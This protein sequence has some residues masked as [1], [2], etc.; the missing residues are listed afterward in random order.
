MESNTI[1]RDGLLDG[2]E[3][4]DESEAEMEPC[5]C[6]LLKK[7]MEPTMEFWSEHGSEAAHG[8]TLMRI[9]SF[10]TGYVFFGGHVEHTLKIWL[11]TDLTK[12]KIAG[13]KCCCFCNFCYDTIFGKSLSMQSLDRT[14][15]T[16]AERSGRTFAAEK[17]KERKR[18]LEE[19]GA[20]LSRLEALYPFFDEHTLYYVETKSIL[21][22]DIPRWRR[23]VQILSGHDLL[24]ADSRAGEKVVEDIKHQFKITPSTHVSNIDLDEGSECFSC[25]VVDGKKKMELRFKTKREFLKLFRAVNSCIKDLG[26]EGLTTSGLGLGSGDT[27][28]VIEGEDEGEDEDED[29]GEDE[30]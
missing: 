20:E 14:A 19:G 5:C 23:V 18:L 30:G 22:E 27:L 3:S 1:D 15:R 10:S 13:G 25:T 11:Y 8:Y 12:H 16:A 21:A 6:G 2:D 26:S 4:D 9:H 7:Q 17:E 29:E 28:E 24:L